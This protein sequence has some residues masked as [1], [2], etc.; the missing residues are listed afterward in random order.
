MLRLCACARP[1]CARRR[2]AGGRAAGGCG[3]A[4][5]RLAV[6]DAAQ[7]PS[8]G[9]PRRGL[10]RQG[11]PRCRRRRPALPAP[12]LRVAGGADAPGPAPMFTDAC[13]PAEVWL[14][15]V[16]PTPP[17]E[18]P[19]A[20][21][22]LAPSAVS[23]SPAMTVVAWGGPLRCVSCCSTY[24]A[25]LISSGLSVLLLAPARTITLGCSPHRAPIWED[26]KQVLRRR[27]QA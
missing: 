5:G 19:G 3:K 12:R 4:H 17:H 16:T 6:D 13:M 22:A 27:P 20:R 26:T 18:R 10:R 21:A 15:P 8:R 1:R 14:A 11:A 2:V 7:A 9:P 25:S 24:M 23:D